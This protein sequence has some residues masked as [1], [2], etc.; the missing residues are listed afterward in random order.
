M[1]HRYY[2]AEFEQMLYKTYSPMLFSQE[3]GSLKYWRYLVGVCEPNDKFVKMVPFK[4][5]K[6]MVER[7]FHYYQNDNSVINRIVLRRLIEI[8]RLET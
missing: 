5:L 3:A 6:Y 8:A 7:E 4:I 2:C 1:Y